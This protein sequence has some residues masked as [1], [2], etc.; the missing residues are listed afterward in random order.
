MENRFNGLQVVQLECGRVTHP[1]FSFTFK[2]NCGVPFSPA[3]RKRKG[4]IWLL[5]KWKFANG[6]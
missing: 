6:K 4:C 1:L 2:V 5:Q 3:Y